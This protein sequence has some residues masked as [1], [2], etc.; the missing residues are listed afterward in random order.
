MT[1]LINHM[2]ENIKFIKSK[3][4]RWACNWNNIPEAHAEKKNVDGFNKI[5]QTLVYKC[6]FMNKIW[7]TSSW[8]IIKKLYSIAHSRTME[9]FEIPIGEKS[10]CCKNVF[11]QLNY[12]HCHI[13]LRLFDGCHRQQKSIAA[14]IKSFE[15]SFDVE[16]EPKTDDH[17]P[18]DK[19][20]Q[21]LHRSGEVDMRP[22]NT[23][24]IN[25]YN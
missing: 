25:R 21:L 23:R 22:G 15:F 19:K 20:H 12:W 8:N 18:R 6:Y 13:R 24:A 11:E 17:C 4:T 2:F 7:I 16:N 1:L 5:R 10:F 9:T 3:S 14:T